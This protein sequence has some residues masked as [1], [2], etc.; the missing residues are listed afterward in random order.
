MQITLAAI[1]DY[2][3]VSIGDKL[4]VLGVFD[5]IYSREF[6]AAHPQ[7]FL[8]IRI[9]FG[10]DDRNRDFQLHIRLENEDGQKAFEAVPSGRIGDV[11]AGEIGSTNLVIGLNGLTLKGPGRYSFVITL[12]ET[13]VRLPLRVVRQDS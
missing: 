11:P 12:G 1:A 13:E 9:Q 3:S 10:F 7:L 5:T 6:P 4:N 8:A 2:A